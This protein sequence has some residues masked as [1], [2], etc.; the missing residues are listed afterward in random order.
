MTKATVIK[1]TSTIR[2]DGEIIYAKQ[3]IAEHED[4]HLYADKD[5]MLVNVSTKF[6]VVGSEYITEGQLV[7]I[8][9]LDKQIMLLPH[10]QHMITLQQVD[11]AQEYIYFKSSTHASVDDIIYA[12]IDQA[13]TT[14]VKHDD[15]DA[16]H[17][18]E[19]EHFG[20]VSCENFGN[21]SM[22]LNCLVKDA[23]LT[24]LSTHLKILRSTIERM[25]KKG[26]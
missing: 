4:E 10:P 3:F 23:P 9:S 5:C 22:Y 2:H 17:K 16:L 15:L 26:E 14:G 19:L 11:A 6:D 7:P 25:Y 13:R 1:Y 12:L 8:S 18:F 21:F 20:K 24:Y